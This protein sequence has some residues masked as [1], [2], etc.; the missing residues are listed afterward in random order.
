MTPYTLMM[1]RKNA[2]GVALLASDMHMGYVLKSVIKNY[3]S[4]K[5]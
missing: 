2:L 4:I 1:I 5:Y 3:E